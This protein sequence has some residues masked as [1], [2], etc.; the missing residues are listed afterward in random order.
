[1]RPDNGLAAF[2]P[3]PIVTSGLG[4]FLSIATGLRPPPELRPPGVGRTPF[5]GLRLTLVS[6]SESAILLH[7]PPRSIE[8]VR[9]F[10]P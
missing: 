5:P 10:I 6:G 4:V 8:E 3:A 2:I 1:M 9:S 7:I